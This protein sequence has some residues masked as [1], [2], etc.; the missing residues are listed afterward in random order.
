MV[1]TVHTPTSCSVYLYINDQKW[2]GKTVW[3]FDPGKLLQPAG[4]TAN[5]VSS[6]IVSAEAKITAVI[7]P[8]G[9]VAETDEDNNKLSRKVRCSAAVEPIPPR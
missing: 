9:E 2:G 4:G 6:L 3:N 1:W 5:Y 8:T 7:D